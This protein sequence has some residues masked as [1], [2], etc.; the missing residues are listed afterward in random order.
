MEIEAGAGPIGTNP[1]GTRVNNV[2]SGAYGQEKLENNELSEG[3][4]AKE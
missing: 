2:K 4:D 1:A 3:S